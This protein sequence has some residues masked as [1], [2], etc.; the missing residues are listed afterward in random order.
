[1]AAT[2]SSWDSPEKVASLRTEV[3]AELQEWAKDDDSL[4]RFL[5]ARK[6]DVA[7]AKKILLRHQEWRVE[8][9]VPRGW[10]A[11]TIPVQE[12][13]PCIRMG[14]CYVRGRDKSRRPLAFLAVRMHNPKVDR[15]TQKRFVTF[16]LDELIT[17]CAEEGSAREFT[18]RWKDW[19][20]R[21]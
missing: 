21:L 14:S 18:V 7:A 11:A 13:E 5:R 19:V 16:A 3:G 6:G 1:M 8:H 4:R 2:E 9:S 15:E 17:R 12:L 10:P 20:L